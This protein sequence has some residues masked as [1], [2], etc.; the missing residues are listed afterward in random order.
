[1]MFFWH[2]L[3]GEF[4]VV[5]PRILGVQQPSPLRHLS[6]LWPGKLHLKGPEVD[7]LSQRLP[8]LQASLVFP[9]IH[10]HA[11]P[12][13]LPIT[14]SYLWTEPLWVL[15]SFLPSYLDLL[16]LPKLVLKVTFPSEL[17][18]WD[19]CNYQLLPISSTHIGLVSL[20][21]SQSLPGVNNK[22]KD[23]F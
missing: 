16:C 4:P 11:P 17:I 5:V 6:T 20:I 9:N 15:P 10:T 18:D 13:F 22:L 21:G 1:M 2:F 14:K 7:P 19:S 3:F 23:S 8:C 12:I